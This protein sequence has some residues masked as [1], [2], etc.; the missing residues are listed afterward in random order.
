MATKRFKLSD[1]CLAFFLGLLVL[2]GSH[3]KSYASSKSAIAGASKL[4]TQLDSNLG[5][6]ELF[7]IANAVGPFVDEIRKANPSAIALKEMKRILNEMRLKTS[8]K[9]AEIEARS[10]LLWP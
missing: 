8:T 2:L 3:N 6:S 10:V 5:A 9:V 7:D 4:S 1:F